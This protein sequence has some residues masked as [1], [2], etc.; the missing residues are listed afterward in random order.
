MQ[1]LEL[2]GGSRTD[3]LPQLQEVSLGEEVSKPVLL[4]HN[5]DKGQ[6]AERDSPCGVSLRGGGIQQEPGASKS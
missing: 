3:H 2:G 5:T 4:G 1:P 6:E